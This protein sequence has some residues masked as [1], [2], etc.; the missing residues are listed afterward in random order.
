M[1][2]E[3]FDP[4]QKLPNDGEQCLLMPRDH[5]GLTTIAVYGPIAWREV[6]KMWVDLFRDPEAGSCV[7]P[8]QVGCWTLWEPIAPPDELPRFTEPKEKE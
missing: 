4:S 7:K 5:G 8:D 3:W 6:D 2:I 1:S